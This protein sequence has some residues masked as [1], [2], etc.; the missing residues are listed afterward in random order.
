MVKQLPHT[1][2]STAT[3]LVMPILGFN[4]G[5]G[6]P[7]ELESSRKLSQADGEYDATIMVI[8]STV[9]SL[10]GHWPTIHPALAR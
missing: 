1:F 8:F 6:Y 4:N 10:T 3:D 7:R 9:H 5:V 2:V